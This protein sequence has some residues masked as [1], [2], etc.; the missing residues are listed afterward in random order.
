MV[1][2]PLIDGHF[3]RIGGYPIF[4]HAHSKP[5]QTNPPLLNPRNGK[6]NST[7]KYGH[8]IL[9]QSHVTHVTD[10]FS[11]GKPHQSKLMPLI[12]FI[13]NHLYISI[14][15]LQH[16]KV[17]LVY[18][19][20]LSIYLPIY[21]SIYLPVYLS[22]YLSIHPSIY[23]SVC[24]SNNSWVPSQRPRS[25]PRLGHS[26]PSP[27]RKRAVEKHLL[28]IPMLSHFFI[29]IIKSWISLLSHEIKSTIYCQWDHSY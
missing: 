4:G 23:L 15:Y 18:L 12:R 13:Q 28:I 17:Y 27:G 8:V 25:H 10:M 19:V 3:N 14:I 1:D 9:K 2:L 20:H 6:W 7:D 16:L 11:N 5:H 26:H 22:V 21:L 29:L 24:I